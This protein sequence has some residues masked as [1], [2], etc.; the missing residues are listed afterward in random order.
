MTW[1]QL[2]WGYLRLALGWCQMGFPASAMVA[3]I[4]FGL[5]E[6]TIAVAVAATVATAISRWLYRGQAPSAA[7]PPPGRFSR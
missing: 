5:T 6:A 4:L 7:A 3:L 1:E 2:K